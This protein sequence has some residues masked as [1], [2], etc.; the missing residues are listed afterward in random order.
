MTGN[1]TTVF[2]APEVSLM[3]DELKE[4]V[5]QVKPGTLVFLP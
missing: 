3:G 2:E 1:H 5:C 4:I